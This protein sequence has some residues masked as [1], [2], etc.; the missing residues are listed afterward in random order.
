MKGELRGGCVEFILAGKFSRQNP[1]KETSVLAEVKNT[2]ELKHSVKALG[3]L[4]KASGFYPV[5]C[6]IQ[7]S[8]VCKVFHI[9]ISNKGELPQ[10]KLTV[11]R[12]FKKNTFK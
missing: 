4:K 7:G 8:T 1:K 11:N 12:L 5:I 9:Y 2:L 3:D 6:Y 10:N